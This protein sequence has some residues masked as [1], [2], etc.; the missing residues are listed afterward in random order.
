[1]YDH[2]LIITSFLSFL[3]FFVIIDLQVEFKDA[4]AVVNAMLL[5]EAEFKGRPLKVLVLLVSSLYSSFFLT[6]NLSDYAQAYQHARN[7]LSS[8][9]NPFLSFFPAAVLFAFSFLTL[10]ILVN[11]QA[12]RPR[13]AR[14]GY[15]PPTG[16]YGYAPR[17][18]GRNRRAVYA[19]Y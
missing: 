8:C 14:G 11:S 12:R 15:F 2:I 3:T 1:M 13:R 19:P 18:R 4:D 16:G 6:F 7:D 9:T 5:N 17:A 10:C